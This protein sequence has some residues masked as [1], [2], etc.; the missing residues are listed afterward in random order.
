MILTRLRAK[1]TLGVEPLHA[2]GDY[3]SGRLAFSLLSLTGSL[4]GSGGLPKLHCVRGD[5]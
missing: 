1:H 4:G 3:E 5:G 2:D